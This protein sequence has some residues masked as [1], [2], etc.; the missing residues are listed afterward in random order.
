MEKI[1]AVIDDSLCVKK[2][3]VP[4]ILKQLAVIKL[5][6]KGGKNESS[7]NVVRT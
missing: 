7:K 2:E 4:L 3:T 1:T 6:S 5:N